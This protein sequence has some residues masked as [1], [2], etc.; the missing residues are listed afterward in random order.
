MNLM[1]VARLPGG[2]DPGE[3]RSEPSGRDPTH[4]LDEFQWSYGD[5]RSRA[6]RKLPHHRLACREWTMGMPSAAAI[7][8]SSGSDAAPIFFMTLPR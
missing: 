4:A 2:G 5:V 7:L 8:T 3:R 1:L 6:A